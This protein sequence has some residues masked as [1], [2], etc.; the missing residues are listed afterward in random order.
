MSYASHFSTRSPKRTFD[1]V[2]TQESF[3]RGEALSSNRRN[4]TARQQKH[5]K[6]RLIAKA[7]P[8]KLARAEQRYRRNE[9]SKRSK[10]SSNTQESIIASPDALA[11]SLTKH[12]LPKGN[13]RVA[14][15]SVSITSNPPT[16][17][18]PLGPVIL[19]EAVQTFPRPVHHKESAPQQSQ[20][21][22]KDGHI[23]VLSKKQCGR[24]P[25][26]HDTK[27]RLHAI[28]DSEDQIAV[29]R[30]DFRTTC[31]HESLTQNVLEDVSSLNNY[32]RGSVQVSSTPDT[33]FQ[34]AR[35]TICSANLSERDAQA[36]N[37][38]ES[39]VGASSSSMESH[40]R[41]KR[42]T[43]PENET[44]VSSTPGGIPSE[45]QSS[46]STTSFPEF[47]TE[48]PSEAASTSNTDTEVSVP[49]RPNRLESGPDR[50]PLFVV[51][52][53]TN[54]DSASV[55]SEEELLRVNDSI[56][57]IQSEESEE[58]E[59]QRTQARRSAADG[60][61]VL[62]DTT[63]AEAVWKQ[64][65]QLH[66]E[67]PFKIG[68]LSAGEQMTI[69]K[70]VARYLRQRQWSEA[71][72]GDFIHS[73]AI[74]R[75]A[76]IAFWS[77]FTYLFLERKP[78]NIREYMCRAYRP[79]FAQSGPFTDTE[80]RQLVALVEELGKDWKQIGR[81][82]NRYREDVKR[83][84]ALLEDVRETSER[85]VISTGAWTGSEEALFTEAMA[86]YGAAKDFV[87]VAR[88]VKTRTQRQCRDHDRM[89]RRTDASYTPRTDR[90]Q[91]VSKK[92]EG[93]RE[94]SLK[95]H[96]P[97]HKHKTSVIKSTAVAPKSRTTESDAVS[98]V[99]TRHHRITD[100]A[101]YNFIIHLSNTAATTSKSPSPSPSP[102]PLSS[103][104][105]V[106]QFTA[107]ESCNLDTLRS[108][109]L[110]HFEADY[111]RANLLKRLTS[112]RKKIKTWR[113]MG[114]RDTLA[115]MKA[116]M[117]QHCRLL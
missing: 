57:D 51:D 76:K 37:L 102:S 29:G 25:D 52:E 77:N 89:R 59:S 63:Q 48:S 18:T 38:S 39:Q 1:H 91:G 3:V 11:R 10:S 55:I 5:E 56:P 90:R 71:D 64:N 62:S 22:D 53:L 72:L 80:K 84:Y 74:Q 43:L 28:H 26:I 111:G 95:Q 109:D 67:A 65:R 100:T 98:S 92:K 81:L 45:Q 50:G 4:A 17:P 116:Y 97:R 79:G 94:G 47:G 32:G 112:Q 33:P 99:V 93:R 85:A 108:V 34:P 20:N 105:P 6:L 117:E 101:L 23:N 103:S 49:D 16:S 40:L 36:D 12:K 13:K 104:L 110:A 61:L 60:N 41:L 30:P 58:V 96:T 27:L 115:A 107:R 21:L 66:L 44:R 46:E 31:R 35:H 75:S 54:E 73:D 42:L 19:S 2:D 24:S 113:T 69:D 68:V 70:V 14:S 88:I 87:N 83:C 15:L 78:Q 7:S 114:A 86:T 9:Q 106:T 82:M 8:E